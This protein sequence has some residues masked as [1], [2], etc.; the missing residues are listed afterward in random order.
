MLISSALSRGLS[1]GDFEYLTIGQV[2]D[3]LLEF[4]PEED[5]VY[6][7]TQEDINAFFH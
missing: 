6:E 5:R 2:I 1:V 3:I 4:A 7:A